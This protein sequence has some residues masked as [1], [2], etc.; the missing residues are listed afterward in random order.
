MFPLIIY[1]LHSYCFLVLSV[2]FISYS[3]FYMVSKCSFSAYFPGTRDTDNFYNVLAIPIPSYLALP[4]LVFACRYH[5]KL[6]TH[7]FF[8]LP[9]SADQPWCFPVLPLPSGMA[10]NTP[11]SVCRKLSFNDHS[12]LIN[13]PHCI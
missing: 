8:P 2:L 9:L 4:R 7:V 12:L 6:L 13:W 10:W 1:G 11:S 5:D 3:W